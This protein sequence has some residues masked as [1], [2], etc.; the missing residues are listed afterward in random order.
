M[1]A[2]AFPD[3]VRDVEIL[4]V[5]LAG[6]IAE[7]ALTVV[8]VMPESCAGVE[9]TLV[10]QQFIKFVPAPNE[11]FAYAALGGIKKLKSISGQVQALPESLKDRRFVMLVD[12]T[13]SIEKGKSLDY[14]YLN[15]EVAVYDQREHKVVWHALALETT[16]TEEEFF[17]KA[18][19][20][21]LTIKAIGDVQI[22]GRMIEHAK[23]NGF[24][25]QGLTN[26]TKA[27]AGSSLVIFNRRVES[28]RKKGMSFDSVEIEP[29][30]KPTVPS[31]M[32][33]RMPSGTYIALSVPPGKYRV[34]YGRKE[35]MEVEVGAQQRRA[36]ELTTGF[37]NSFRM[38]EVTGGEL[39]KLSS[40]AR[41]FLLPD[42]VGGNRYMGELAWS[43]IPPG[44]AP[45]VPASVIPASVVP[46]PVRQPV[47]AARDTAR[48]RFFGKL[49]TKL[50]FYENRMCYRGGAKGTDVS[51]ADGADWAWLKAKGESNSIGMPDTDATLRIKAKTKAG[52]DDPYFREFEIAAGKP[53]TI[54]MSDSFTINGGLSGQS[55]LSC[56]VGGSFIP[57]AGGDYEA[58]FEMTD[59]C[60]VHVREISV[61]DDQVRQF[62]VEIT[63][64]HKCN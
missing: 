52:R 58:T 10:C 64:V 54:A 57:A 12:W 56:Q 16:L 21:Y 61:E 44:A 62:P 30:P 39:A 8:V 22:Y 55:T 50:D 40:S 24:G 4:S 33:L 35:E 19:E 15:G 47:R 9:Q 36:Y 37:S 48:I 26:G 32:S 23:A 49:G 25:M 46:A 42:S 31:P 60:V 43:D 28:S 5:N 59:R 41:N 38:S 6:R 1:P 45:A 13:L 3:S 14:L 7:E 63:R 2:H 20:K 29:L 53:V 51:G 27:D 11:K 34:S 18:V 17:G